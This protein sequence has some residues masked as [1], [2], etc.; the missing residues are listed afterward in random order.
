MI[1]IREAFAH[2]FRPKGLAAAPRITRRRVSSMGG[3][4]RRRR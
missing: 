2:G 3:R 1:R 4:A